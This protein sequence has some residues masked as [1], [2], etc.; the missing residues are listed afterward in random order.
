MQLGYFAH[1]GAANA[2]RRKPR[3]NPRVCL[4]RDAALHT[5]PACAARL[6][7]FQP[8]PARR[9]ARRQETLEAKSIRRQRTDR[10]RR[11]GR[12]GPGNCDDLEAGGS[13]G[14][15]QF[16]T[17]IADGRRAGIAHQRNGLALAQPCNDFNRPRRFVVIMQ[18]SLRRLNAEML[19]TAFRCGAC[20]PPRSGHSFAGFAR[21]RA[22][23]AE[24]ADRSGDDVEPSCSGRADRFN[25]HYNPR[26]YSKSQERKGMAVI[27]QT[28]TGVPATRRVGSVA[29]RGCVQPGQSCGRSE[30][31]TRA[32]RAPGAGWQACR[33]RAR[34]RRPRRS[35]A[36]RQRQ[37][38]DA[39]RRAMG[40]R[41]QC[42]GRQAGVCRRCRRRRAPNSPTPRA[43]V[44]AEIAY[45][46]NDPAR[47]IR[48]L[49]QIA[50]ADGARS[51]AELLLDPRPQRIPHGPSR[52]RHARPGRARTFSQR[53]RRPARESRRAATSGCAPPPSTAHR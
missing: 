27:S 37:L 28:S 10:Q 19:A 22:Q 30:R 38:R 15:H 17:R 44:A 6:Q 18:R 7:Q 53:P 13:H 8:L 46:E 50:G 34:L 12:A 20:P 32:C 11:D 29:A 36:S 4:A 48:E 47:A 41:R 42:R 5:A 35:I 45:A 52:R 23:I 33:G 2:P 21:P 51:G 25:S 43:L 26:L 31:Q 40:G 14:A 39:E 1:H 16:K 9:A 3:R 49:D 24:I